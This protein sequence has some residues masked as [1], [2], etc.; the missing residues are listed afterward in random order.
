MP[1]ERLDFSLFNP[2]MIDQK[3][4]GPAEPQQH[5]LPEELNIINHKLNK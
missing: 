2:E 3:Q 1:S 4:R 5:T